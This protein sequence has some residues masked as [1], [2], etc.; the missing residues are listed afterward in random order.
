MHVVFYQKVWHNLGDDVSV[1]VIGI[2]HG[3]RPLDTFNKTNIVLILKVRSPT[4][5]SEFRPIS[6]RD[7]IYKLASKVLANQLKVIFP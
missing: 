6:L 1:V 4:P 3:T 5:V 7:V 2:I